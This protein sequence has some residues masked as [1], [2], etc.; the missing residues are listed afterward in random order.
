MT[1]HE[2]FLY[3]GL[4][5]ADQVA[6]AKAFQ[7]C[8]RL[9]GK[10]KCWP[11]DKLK[12]PAFEGFSTA[13]RTTTAYLGADARPLLMAFIGQFQK[14]GQVA[15]RRS[16][17]KSPYCINPMHYYWGSRANVSLENQKDKKKQVSPEIVEAMRAERAE[18]KRV[19]D[20]ARK[21]KF[22][23]SITRRICAGETYT[24][25]D[26][27]EQESS[28]DFQWELL[29]EVCK[30]LVERYPYEARNRHLAV[31]VSNQLE[32]PW[33]KPGLPGHKGN[34]GL[35]GE[36]LDCMEEIKNGRCTVDVTQFS[37]DW[38][39]QVKRFWEQ[40]DIKGADECWPWLGTTRRGKSE[41]IAYFPSPFHSGKTQ[42][43]P[44]VAF[45]LSRGYTGKYKVFSQPTCEPFCCN[46]RHLTIREFK[47]L[48]PPA[49]IEK[50]Q[51]H[52]GNIFDQY[53]KSIQQVQPDSAQ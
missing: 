50:I 23:Y 22:S 5:P 17:C 15:V 9:R 19:L 8:L 10:D 36:C 21:Y 28:E 26:P 31:H 39:W 27:P 45:W 53:R 32:C 44:R 20:I 37:L 49:K 38:Y 40:V 29:I 6:F 14:D 48:L 33:H 16:I 35:M 1:L 51:L 34:F 30:G 43:A 2:V 13:N 12:H 25:I 41:S 4:T 7:I 24:K 47:D 11:A 46:P 52:H 3:A 42:S 18:G